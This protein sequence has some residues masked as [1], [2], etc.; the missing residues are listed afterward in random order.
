MRLSMDTNECDQDRVPK[1]HR[2]PL[3]STP[4]AADTWPLEGEALFAHGESSR[5]VNGAAVTVSGLH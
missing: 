4:S 3:Q 1:L 5:Q 2:A